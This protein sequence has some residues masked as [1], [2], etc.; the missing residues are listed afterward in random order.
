MNDR[1]KSLLA[2]ALFA[3]VAL[4]AAVQLAYNMA[5][6][7]SSAGPLDFLGL[8]NW[9]LA[10]VIFA[11]VGV[12][13][14]SRQP[15]NVIGLLLMLPALVFA[16][17]VDIYLNPI[18]SPP[19]DPSLLLYVAI[20]FSNWGWLL[21]IMPILF[22]LVLFPTGKPYTP[23]WRWLFYWGLAMSAVMI[24]FTTFS[25][26][27]GPVDGEGS[28]RI[29][30]PIGF[31]PSGSEVMALFEGVWF[32]LLPLLTLCCAAALFVRFRRSGVVER[33]QI[34]WL[35]YAGALFAA[36]YAFGFTDN[37]LSDNPL[38][39][40]AFGL[41]LWTIP[42]AIGIAILRY[43]LFD[44]DIIIR[45]TVLY[46]LLTAV[47]LALYFGLVLL[48]QSAFVALTGEESA[49]AIVLS[50]LVIA[51][52]FNPL[53]RRLQAFLDRRFYRRNYDAV[54]ALAAFARTARD[55]VDMDVLT[56]DLVQKIEETMQPTRLAVWLKGPP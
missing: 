12:L 48:A 50:T 45:K 3:L 42:L 33:E 49:L 54:L 52:V 43:H 4:S 36:V 30:N 8:F 35:F 9:G 51:A 27:I 29:V 1:T 19:P 5:H 55:E 26:D 21:L 7:P 41:S 40:F 23:R 16:I 32:V 2:W 39:N 10:P 38:W 6:Q 13:I 44:I 37:E 18:T 17:P 47:L 34:K 22:M 20:W 28:W 14:I 31:V 56:A 24:L 11:F 53:R 46:G 25:R 15:G